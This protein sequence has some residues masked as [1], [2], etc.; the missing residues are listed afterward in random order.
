MTSFWTQIFTLLTSEAG[1]LAYHLVLAFTIAG[2][3]QLAI[4]RAYRGS[5]RGRRAVVG[6]GLLLALQ[7]ILFLVVGLAWQGLFDS[8]TWLPLVDRVVTLISLVIIVWLWAFPRPSRSADATTALLF[9]LVL[10][11]AAFGGTWWSGQVSLGTAAIQGS[12]VDMGAQISSLVVLAIGASLLL[13]GR[14]DGW[15]VGLVM[16]AMLFAGHLVQMLFPTLGGEYPAAVRLAQIAAFPFLLLLPQHFAEPQ[17][18]SSAVEVF[19]TNIPVVRGDAKTL[20]TLLTR[21]GEGDRDQLLEVTAVVIAEWMN[22][23]ICNLITAPDETNPSPKQWGFDRISG[24]TLPAVTLDEQASPELFAALHLGR[25]LRLE[26]PEAEKEAPGLAAQLQIDQLGGLISVPVPNTGDGINLNILLLSPYSLHVWTAEEQVAL[27]EIA[28][29][30]AHFLQ[31]SQQLSA[32]LLDQENLREQISALQ[33]ENQGLESQLGKLRQ[34]AEQGRVQI[35]SLAAMVNEQEFSRIA[36]CLDRSNDERAEAGDDQANAQGDLRLA[37]LEVALLRNALAE[38]DQKLQA[39]ET[40]GS[41]VE[42]SARAKKPAVD[43][44][45]VEEVAA[46]AKELRQPLASIVGYTDILLGETM[47]ILVAPQRKSLEKI[48]AAT[49]RMNRLVDDLLERSISPAA[50]LR[51]S[52]E[53]VDIAWIIDDA[54]AQTSEQIRRKGIA[55]RLELPESIPFVTGDPEALLKVLVRLL[56]QAERATMEDGIIWLRVRVEKREGQEDFLLIQVADTGPGLP[57]EEASQVFSPSIPSEREQGGDELDL[58]GVKSLVEAHQGRI[59]VDSD[60]G[61]GSIFSMLLPA[62]GQPDVFD[63]GQEQQG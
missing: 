63:P 14:P 61:H 40:Q 3:F 35:Q 23:D 26:P 24:R 41:S 54:V 31:H 34:E 42:P 49:E 2:A 47:G 1:S 38:A 39:A 37:L 8:R 62:A 15:G 45:R 46:I 50:S 30:L 32:A 13:A 19:G 44:E 51:I 16:L 52:D 7:L 27:A 10:A 5:R 28:R 6:L 18:A 60:P 59:W 4:L 58:A 57:P 21:A 20:S 22:A 25:T 36:S 56:S 48:R 9:L 17:A 33:Q 43:A 29:A 11:L 55:L 53:P 12:V